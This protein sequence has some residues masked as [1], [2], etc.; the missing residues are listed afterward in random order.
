MSAKKIMFLTP[1]LRSG[2]A[3]KMTKMIFDALNSDENFSASLVVFDSP[4]SM[5]KQIC[6]LGQK[7]LRNCLLPLIRI[8]WEQRPEVV[9]SSF[10]YITFVLCVLKPF[11]NFKLVARESNTLSEKL[12]EFGLLRKLFYLFSYRFLYTSCDVIV[13]Q[14]IVM[15]RDLLSYLSS[16]SQE[17][18]IIIN[19]FI[20]STFDVEQVSNTHLT[21]GPLRLVSVGRLVYQKAFDEC[22]DQLSQVTKEI[23]LDIFGDGEERDIL[24]KL[25]ASKGMSKKIT[26]KGNVSREELIASLPKY[27]YLLLGSRYEGFSNSMLEALCAG[28]PVLAKSFLG[29]VEETLQNGFNGYI[30]DGSLRDLSRV[31]DLPYNF[32]KTLIIKDV[33]KRFNKTEIV[34]IYTKM[35]TSVY[36]YRE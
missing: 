10:G 14:S 1:H 6:G 7:R 12:K 36:Q 8:F 16:A 29:G 11:F 2:G 13:A 20:D 21:I 9:F 18:V 34:K 25:I 31:L 17:R 24:E 5:N 33:L 30:Y 35:F 4:K 19:N 27:H 15:K 22:I 23:T 26:L 32:N 3:E 28:L